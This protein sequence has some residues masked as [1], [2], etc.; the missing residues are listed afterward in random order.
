M[1]QSDL[2]IRRDLDNKPENTTGF[3]WGNNSIRIR[4]NETLR[5]RRCPRAL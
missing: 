3:I 4:K 2:V 5:H 1:K